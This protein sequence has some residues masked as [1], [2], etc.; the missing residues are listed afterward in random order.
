MIS[1]IAEGV[2]S[3]FY[4]IALAFF[5]NRKSQLSAHYLQLLDSGGAVH[6]AGG[7]QG[8]LAVE[9]LHIARQLGGG[10]G[11]T[12]ALKAHH[13]DDRGAVVGES[14]LGGAAAHEVRQFLVDDLYHLLSGSQAVQHV[15]A[16]RPLRYGGHEF[17]DHLVAHVGLQ[18]R[19]TDL[20]HGFPDVIFRQPAFAPQAS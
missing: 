18:Q 5:K 10:G 15:S 9:L 13:H 20:P 19:Q 6:V 2:F 4:G 16:H 12:G 3:D 1:G 14:Q 17:L 7:Q 11:L 8:P